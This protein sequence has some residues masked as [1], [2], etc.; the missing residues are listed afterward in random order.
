MPPV[1][2]LQEGETVLVG[3]CWLAIPSRIWS[4]AEE[5]P[6]QASLA[7]PQNRDPVYVRPRT[8]PRSGARPGWEVST[9][10]PALTGEPLAREP[11]PPPPVPHA[12]EAD[13]IV[14]V[15]RFVSVPKRGAHVVLIV[16]PGAAAQHTL[17]RTP[18]ADIIL[19]S[20]V[21]RHRASRRGGQG[22]REN[23]QRKSRTH[24]K[25]KQSSR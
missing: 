23:N 1:A 2:P 20:C 24:R 15:V 4:L 3:A 8:D 6:G 21:A 10:P 9:R 18:M 7:L 25:P 17:G 14:P 5:D 12:P 11:A 13:V 19:E 22:K 16:V